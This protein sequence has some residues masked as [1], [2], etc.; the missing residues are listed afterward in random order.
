MD[1]TLQEIVREA[2]SSLAEYRHGLLLAYPDGVTGG[3]KDF[4]VTDGETRLEISLE[5]GPDRVIALLRLPTLTAHLRF[6][7]GSAE[8]RAKM[9]HRMDLAMR[10]GGG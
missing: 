10:R 6:T 2:S 8:D 3:P 9:L 5:P 1:E 4:V 7:H